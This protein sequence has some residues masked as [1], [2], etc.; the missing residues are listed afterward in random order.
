MQKPLLV[1]LFILCGNNSTAF[2][3]ITIFVSSPVAREKTITKAM[4]RTNRLSP[5][6]IFRAPRFV[7]FVAGPVIIKAA[8]LPMLIPEASHCCNSGMVPPPQA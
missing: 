7:I 8:A 2:F 6:T 4:Y 1:H 5:N 3:Q